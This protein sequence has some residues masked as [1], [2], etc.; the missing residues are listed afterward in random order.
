[1]RSLI[2]T[3]MW[4]SGPGQSVGGG[5]WDRGFGRVYFTFF[6]GGKLGLRMKGLGISGFWG[7]GGVR[8]WGVC[9][10]LV[11]LLLPLI[12]QPGS[13]RSLLRRGEIGR[14]DLGKTPVTAPSMWSHLAKCSVGFKGLASEVQGW[15]C[16]HFLCTPL[17]S[18]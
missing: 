18:S 16:C 7:C 17:G 5:G 3:Q 4:V 11:F 14:R 8:V 12:P 9:L 15:L 10:L 13:Q 2:D 6:L 1:M